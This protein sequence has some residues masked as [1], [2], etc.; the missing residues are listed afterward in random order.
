MCEAG[1]SSGWKEA[2][3]NLPFSPDLC[4]LSTQEATGPQCQDSVSRTM[5]T[6][7]ESELGLGDFPVYL[8]GSR[9][10]GAV[11]LAPLAQCCSHQ[12]SCCLNM[13]SGVQG[14]WFYSF[15]KKAEG[16]MAQP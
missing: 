4:G 11:G 16:A 8:R 1:G 3:N 15:L 5:F 13:E 14:V 10:W 9:P 2:S 12:P 7:A 6:L